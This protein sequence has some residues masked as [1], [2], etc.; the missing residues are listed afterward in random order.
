[1]LSA[2][3]NDV[4]RDHP[5]WTLL[6]GE[7]GSGKTATLSLLFVELVKLIKA[8]KLKAV[9]ILIQLRAT[10]NPEDVEETL[11]KY[12]DDD[13]LTHLING[14]LKPI[15][16]LDSLDEFALRYGH[17]LTVNQIA[18]N[19]L[20][21]PMLKK[22]TIV[23]S[24]RPNV[25]SD[26][27][28]L[29]SSRA[30]FPKQ[31]QLKDLQLL[32]VIEYLRPYGLAPVF[33]RLNR[34]LHRLLTKPLFLYFFVKGSRA[35]QAPAGR[36]APVG[37]DEAKLFDWFYA[38]WYDRAQV[39]MGLGHAL[40]NIE[41]IRELLESIAIQCMS[42]PLGVVSEDEIRA[43]VTK[44]AKAHEELVVMVLLSQAKERW[45]L[46]PHYRQWAHV[47]PI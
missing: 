46:V 25:I 4:Q 33:E 3:V 21:T 41:V 39:Q 22:C 8:R 32:D 5:A 42:N 6:V 10:W 27:E 17:P 24:T 28:R 34:D 18:E 38:E 40:P 15:L 23:L 2:L 35:G 9:P 16:L 45:F 29:K 12:I 36:G 37:G 43:S 11:R 1:V 7:L 30:I 13:L 14:G 20:K 26:L 19:V 31:Y 47:V 44:L